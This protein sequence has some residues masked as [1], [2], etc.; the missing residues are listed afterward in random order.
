MAFLNGT[1][2]RQ[3]QAMEVAPPPQHGPRSQD[4]VTALWEAFKERF[5]HSRG[6]G[7]RS[8]MSVLMKDVFGGQDGLLEYLHTGEMGRVAQGDNGGG[9]IEHTSGAGEDGERQPPPWR[10]EQ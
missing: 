3:A 8:K 5:K 2:A 7:W 6:S 9:H 1:S 10:C 4:E